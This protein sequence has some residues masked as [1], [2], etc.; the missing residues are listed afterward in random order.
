M[1]TIEIIPAILPKDFHELEDKVSY[2]E[3]NVD[4]VQI[5]VCDGQFVQ[6]ATWPYKKQDESFDALL[7]EEVGLPG[8][9]TLNYEIDLMV[10]HP[11]EV[12]EDWIIAGANRIILHEECDGGVQDA[13]EIIDNRIE[14]GLAFNIDTEIVVREGISSIQLMGI[15]HIGFQGQEFDTKVIDKIKEARIKYPELPI[16]IDGGVSM[17]T[18]E[19]LINAGADRLV[20]GSAIFNTPNVYEALEQFKELVS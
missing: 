12:V 3:G 14:V 5:D 1:N 2:V 19:M 20:V 15:D 4:T 11:R 7:K 9:E 13:I 17:K 8:W 6:N 18:A 10:N 16:T